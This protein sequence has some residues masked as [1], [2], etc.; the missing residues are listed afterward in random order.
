[1]KLRK[2]IIDHV[3]DSFLETN[4]PLLDLIN[5]AKSGD[6]QQLEECIRIFM[7]HADKLLEVLQTDRLLI[8][9]DLFFKFD[10]LWNQGVFN[11]LFNV[12]R[13]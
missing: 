13:L 7:D 11:G 9:R 12:K 8:H 1:L 6:Q 3:S 4:L 10:L 5:T 2:A